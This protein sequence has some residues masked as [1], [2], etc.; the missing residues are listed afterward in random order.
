MRFLFNPLGGGLC[1]AFFLVDAVVVRLVAVDAFL[2]RV[3]GLF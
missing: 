3:V 2:F 1:L